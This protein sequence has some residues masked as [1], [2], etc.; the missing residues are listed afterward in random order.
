MIF[1][2]RCKILDSYFRRIFFTYMSADDEQLRDVLEEE[3][4]ANIRGTL[5]HIGTTSLTN[6]NKLDAYKM[7]PYVR[8]C[9]IWIHRG[10]SSKDL[11]D[12]MHKQLALKP[13]EDST[14]HRVNFSASGSAR[15]ECIEVA[16]DANNKVQAV[17]FKTN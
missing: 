8:E 1:V 5:M 6:V 17:H 12:T 10:M 2:D 9:N 13:R 3:E 16:L 4:R 7:D 14:L 11:L 15:I